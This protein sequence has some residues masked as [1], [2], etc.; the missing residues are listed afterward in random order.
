M[1][2]GSDL[3]NLRE[4][5]NQ[6]RLLSKSIYHKVELGVEDVSH[7]NFVPKWLLDSDW[8]NGRWGARF[9]SALGRDEQN[10]A[11]NAIQSL[12]TRSKHFPFRHSVKYW[13]R[14]TMRRIS[15]CETRYTRSRRC[16]LRLSRACRRTPC[17]NK[18]STIKYRPS[19]WVWHHI[20][21]AL[22]FE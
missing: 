4:G 6:G 7:Q 13:L 3:R 11:E 20:F 17:W 5:L 2:S 1:P 14:A 10:V 18:A 8:G 12:L 16:W 9:G 21:H 15:D 19:H 22:L